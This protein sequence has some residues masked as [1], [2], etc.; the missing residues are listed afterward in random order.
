MFPSVVD[1]IDF[2]IT[3]VIGDDDVTNSG[4][5]IDL[6]EALRAVPPRSPT[7]AC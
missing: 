3:H 1:D 2:G 7:T 6:F 5:Q 4:V